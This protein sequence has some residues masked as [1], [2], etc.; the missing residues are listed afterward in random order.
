MSDELIYGFY[1]GGRKKGELF[2][3]CG[4]LIKKQLKEQLQRKKHQKKFIIKKL[5]KNCQKK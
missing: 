1:E 4:N 3:N 2:A 5:L